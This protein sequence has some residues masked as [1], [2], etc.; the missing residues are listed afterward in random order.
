ML[1][2]Y[3]HI[4][5]IVIILILCS[6]IVNAKE[7]SGTCLPCEDVQHAA[8]LA[9]IEKKLLVFSNN[10]L[11]LLDEKERDWYETF[12]KGGLLFDGWQEISDDVV[13][14]VPE[15]EKVKTK[16]SMLALGLKIGCEWSKENDVRKIS[17]DMLKDWGKVIKKTVNKS[18]HEISV[19]ISSIEHEVDRLLF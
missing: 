14:R 1:P 8:D 13:A 15:R 12:Q 11:E 9:A 6:A 18:P 17:T 16:V 19:V 10:S 4:S 3:F 7:N 5:F 2:K